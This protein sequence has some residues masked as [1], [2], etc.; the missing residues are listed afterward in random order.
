MHYIRNQLDNKA[1][2]HRPRL[3]DSLDTLRYS[4]D[5]GVATLTLHRPDR[6]NAWTIRMAVELDLVL[7]LVDRDDDVRVLVVTGAGSVF[8][9]GADLDAGS[10]LR[11]GD[12]PIE[13]PERPL[14]PSRVGK[15][16]IAAMN[17]HA[18][19]AGIS[20]A[21]HCDLRLLAEGAKVG[22]A[23]GR[24][25]VIA[26]MGM[27]WLLPRV[28]GMAT[29]MDLLLTGRNV[30]AA[31]ALSVGLVHRVVAADRVLPE[32]MRIARDIA[33]RV[34]PLSAVVTKR[35]VWDA[36]E[37]PW[38]RALQREQELFELLAAHPDAGEGVQS[39]LDKRPPRWTGRPSVDLP[40]EVGGT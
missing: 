6:G 15:P 1:T 5:D 30:E 25:G 24:R 28:V 33:T 12:E 39:F 8:S 16:V 37:E 3:P 14:L 4:V 34:A 9:V 2:S 7:R 32:A 13:P 19:G 10:I 21:T 35:L 20:F 23:F 31:E 40:A 36:M 11:P 29:A 17:G 18:V 27:H 26:E 22:F 38:D